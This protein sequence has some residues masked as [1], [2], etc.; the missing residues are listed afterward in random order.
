MSDGKAWIT[1]RK[2]PTVRHMPV[3]PADTLATLCRPTSHRPDLDEWTA[4]TRLHPC[5]RC[6]TILRR[7]ARQMQEAD[8]D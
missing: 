2:N 3:P 5:G 4:D 7:M 1:T 6:L 8:D